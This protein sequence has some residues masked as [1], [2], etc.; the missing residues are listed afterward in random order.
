MPKYHANID[1]QKNQLQNAVVHPLGSAPSTPVEGQIYFNTTS[2]HIFFRTDTTWIDITDALTLGGNAASF[3]APIASPTFTGTVSGITKA[4]V[5]LANV[6][7]TSDANKP[8]STAQQTALDLKANLASPTLTGTPLAP[9]AAPGTNTTQIATTAFTIAEIGARLAAADALVYKGAIDASANP[10]Y[11]AGDAGDTYRISVAGKI[12]GASGPNVQVGDMLILHTDASAAGTQAAVGANWDI[13]QTNIDG[14]VTVDATQTLTQKTINLSNNTLSGTIA[15]F[16]TALSDADF[17]TLDGSESLSNKTIVT[18]TIASFVNAT[19]NHQNAAG[20]GTLAEAALATTDITTNNVTST[21]HGFAPKSP[22]NAAQF[23]NG[24][25]TPAY[26]AVTDADLS[27]TD[28]TTNNVSSTKH[29]F[30]PKSPADATL[31]L[32][33]AAAPAFAAVKDSDLSTTDITTNN[34][35]TVKHGFLPKLSGDVNQYLN[36]NGGWSSPPGSGISKYAAA[37]GDNSAT[38][39]VLTHSLGTRDISVN[40]IRS[41]TPWDAV[42]ADWEA[43]STT[44]ATIRFASAPTTGEFRVTIIG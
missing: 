10:N 25:A 20:G 44:T 18:P 31:F 34:A 39:F 6:D 30:A 22:G 2:K 41:T 17:A 36:G 5:G 14:A 35:T 27:T 16:N 40:I 28:V 11:P 3:Y 43:T 38:S 19:H 32:N 15:Q 37:I 8:V 4:M 33:G 26:A 23:L 1:L 42:I 24:A 21:K 29:G 12:G 13:I 9:T 7:N